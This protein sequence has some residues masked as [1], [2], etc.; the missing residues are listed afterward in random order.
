[1]FQSEGSDEDLYIEP[2]SRLEK[3]VSPD[4][5]QSIFGTS[6]Q[7]LGDTNMTALKFIADVI[8]R[9]RKRIFPKSSAYYV[10][11]ILICHAEE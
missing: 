6:F 7:C 10:E 4:Q 11:F 8:S 5:M 1:M 9:H 2:L 3:A